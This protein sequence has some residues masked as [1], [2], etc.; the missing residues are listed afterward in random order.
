[1]IPLVIALSFFFWGAKLF[2][3]MNRPPNDAIEVY[4]VGK[5][6]MWKVQHADG[7]R[8]INELH[9]PVGPRRAPDDDLR[10]RDP[11]F[12]RARVPHEAGR[13]ARA[14]HDGL[15]RGDQAGP[16]PPLLR[17]VLRHEAL[18]DDRLGRRDG[19]G[20][21]PGVALGR[22]RAPS[23]SRRPAPSSSS[24]TPATPATAPDSLARGPNLEGLFGKTVQLCR[25]AH[26][27]RR[28]V[29]H[30]RVDPH[31][32][33]RR[34]SSGS[35]R[36]CRRS[37]GSSARRSSCSSWPT[38][39]RC[40]SPLNPLSP[41]ASRPAVRAPPAIQPP[42]SSNRAAPPPK[43]K[44]KVMSA[45]VH[46]PGTAGAA[47]QL[48][49]R[50]LRH[51]VVAP[52]AGPQADRAAVPGLDQRLLLPRR[53]LRAAHPAGAADAGRRPRAGGDVQQAL[54]DARGHD[55]L[56]L[57]D[58]GDPGRAREL[59]HPDDDRGQGPRVPEAEPSLLVHLRRRRASSRS[60]RSCTAASTRAGPSTRRTARPPPTRTSSRRPSA[61]FITGFSSI[62]TGLNFIVTIHT[63]R[64]PGLT[65]VP[66][67]ALRLG[68]LRDE[69]DHRARHAG[70]RRHDPDGRRRAGAS[71]SASSIR[72]SAATRSSSS[73]SSGSTRTRRSTS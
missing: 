24:A 64:A 9:V 11:R 17:A 51:P 59:L 53:P 18:G 7:Q 55:D 21:L 36:S 70:R 3:A 57:P 58:P 10:G 33:T 45:A 44:R 39:S 35:S 43:E 5:Q 42:A 38:S 20:G 46:E 34:S 48:P 67:A 73:T 32:A 23:R 12:L 4:V 41:R 54:H 61:I 26:G 56:L 68:A 15:V 37:R 22:R 65:L 52:D 2:F 71:T 62:L 31:A 63:M 40:R 47:R 13:A 1:M 8:E 27:R 69:P 49:E 14:L 19:A 6:W 29:V 28:R 25:R 50:H 60:G 72:R 16:L 30:P 66:A